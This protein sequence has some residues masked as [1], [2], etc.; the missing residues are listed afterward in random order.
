M[1]RRLVRHALGDVGVLPEVTADI[2][3]ALAEACANV[4]RHSGPGEPFQVTVRI[5]S[6][7]CE[8]R[9]VDDGCG[10][11]SSTVD[12]RQLPPSPPS[13]ER[14]RGFGLMTSLVDELELVSEPERGT[15][16][17]LV[18]NLVFG[19]QAP[20]RSPSPQPT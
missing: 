7:Q 11:D 18:K 15:Q 3:V 9:V 14:G 5:G 17:R 16:V 1:T 13:A 6:E 8:L 2:E 10:F 4:L 19:P 12:L 20:G